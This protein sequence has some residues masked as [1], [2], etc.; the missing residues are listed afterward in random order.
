MQGRGCVRRLSVV[1]KKQNKTQKQH[2]KAK[3]TKQ[4]K[5]L[6]YGGLGVWQDG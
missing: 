6:G 3:N 2:Q 1:P 5:H 4:Q